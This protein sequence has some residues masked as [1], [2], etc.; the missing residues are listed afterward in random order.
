MS[1]MKSCVVHHACVH[2]CECVYVCVCVCGGG[3]SCL[4]AALTGNSEVIELFKA[5]GADCL[6]LRQMRINAQE[7]VYVSAHKVCS[8]NHPSLVSRLPEPMSRA[9]ACVKAFYGC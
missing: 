6:A 8:S 5:S 3:G 1:H 4:A 2:V 7:R 9:D